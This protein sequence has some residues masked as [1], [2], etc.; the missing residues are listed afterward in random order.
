MPAS[1]AGELLA[2]SDFDFILADR[3]IKSETYY[4]S[5]YSKAVGTLR[6]LDNGMHEG[7]KPAFPST[8]LDI[9][10]ELSVDVIIGPDYP[11]DRHTTLSE[12]IMFRTYWKGLTAIVL[13]LDFNNRDTALNQLISAH[14]CA[15]RADFKIICLPYRIRKKVALNE[16]PFAEGIW[17]HFLGLNNLDELEVMKNLAKT[18]SV[19]L[20]TGKP[21]RLGYDGIDMSIE[22]PLKGSTYEI[23]GYPS[24]DVQWNATSLTLEQKDL[25]AWNIA[26]VKK[27]LR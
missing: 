12:T 16:F 14:I 3:I 9:A 24:G 27:R 7:G 22:D 26:V 8:L 25:I 10:S 20:D 18:N 4:D 1:I 15:I 13:Q 17:Y 11:D 19:S 21:F 5:F 2:L 23:K 6:I